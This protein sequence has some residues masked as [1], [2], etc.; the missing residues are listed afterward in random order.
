EGP[1]HYLSRAARAL[2]GQ[3]DELARLMRSY[4]ELRYAHDEPPTEPLRAFLHAVRDFRIVN[5][6]K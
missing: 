4:L 1:Q 3:R 5:V 6:V 2:P